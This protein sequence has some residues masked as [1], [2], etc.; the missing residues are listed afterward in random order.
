MR[1]YT[2]QA[3]SLESSYP[4]QHLVQPMADRR[5]WRLMGDIIHSDDPI[6]PAE[7]LLCDAVEPDEDRQVLLSTHTY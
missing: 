2:N 5:E 3:V 6:R 4:H 1:I 7:I